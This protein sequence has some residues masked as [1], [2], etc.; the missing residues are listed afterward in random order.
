MPKT[1][2]ITESDMKSIVLDIV[3]ASTDTT[4]STLFNAFALLLTHPK[5]AKKL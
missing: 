1:E 3:I 4:A 5:V 2:I